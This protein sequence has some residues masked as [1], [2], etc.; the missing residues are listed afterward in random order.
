MPINYGGVGLHDAPWV[1]E[2][3]GEYYIYSGSNGC[4]NLNLQT[5]KT[6]YENYTNGTPVVVYESYTNYSPAD[7]TF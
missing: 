1:T 6:I 3:G 2:F 4:I 7:H 5:A